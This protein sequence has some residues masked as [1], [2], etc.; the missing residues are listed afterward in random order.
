MSLNS[1]NPREAIGIEPRTF[2]LVTKRSTPGPF[3]DLCSLNPYPPLIWGVLSRIHIWTGQ[4]PSYVW[5]RKR[6][7]FKRRTLSFELAPPP[8]SGGILYI[9]YNIEYLL[10]LLQESFWLEI[11]LQ[12]LQHPPGSYRVV[13]FTHVSEQGMPWVMHRVAGNKLELREATWKTNLPVVVTTPMTYELTHSSLEWW[14]VPGYFTLPPTT[15]TYNLTC[16]TVDHFMLMAWRQHPRWTPI[17][18]SDQITDCL[19]QYLYTEIGPSS[20]PA[21][22]Q[23]AIIPVAGY[24]EELLSSFLAQIHAL[25]YLKFKL[26]DHWLALVLI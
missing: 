9:L 10:C 21:L 12:S 16:R 11:E 3:Q 24:K 18:Y 8:L 5:K 19:K 20:R 14:P 1:I 4:N 23:A 22:Q 2:G 26:Q 6:D 25:E 17:K 13:A 7:F 15:L